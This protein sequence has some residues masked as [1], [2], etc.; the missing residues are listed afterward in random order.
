MDPWRRGA[1][2]SVA[3]VGDDDQATGFGHQEVGP[4]HSH[5][6]V[7][8][9]LPQHHPRHPRHLLYV[10]GV[11]HAQ[12][13]REQTGYLPPRL[14]QGRSHQVGRRLLSQ[15]DDVFAQV[16]LKDLNPIRFQDVI[17]SQFFRHHGLAFRDCGHTAGPRNLRHDGVGLRRVGGEMHL[18]PGRRDIP[19]QH[20]Q[21]VV[22]VRDGVFFHPPGLLSPT[23]P[24]LRSDLVDGFSP[25]PIEPAA[26]PAQR[27]AQLLILH[28]RPGSG[29][30]IPR[31]D[32]SHVSLP[33]RPAPV[34]CGAP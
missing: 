23:L 19:F 20:G 26:G 17:Q 16:G 27:L 4:A 12:L 8:E 30:K 7:Q 32:F 1:Q 11:G 13:I 2:P 31:C 3:L 25:C 9:L 22:Q 14:V 5:V 21:V 29:N 24:H 28:C 10:V 33:T 15:L 18:S 6:G 34:R